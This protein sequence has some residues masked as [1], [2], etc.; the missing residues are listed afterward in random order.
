MVLKPILG[1]QLNQGHSLSQI[2]AAYWLMN[3]GGGDTIFD[4]SGKNLD[5]TL[6]N[7][8][9]FVACKFGTGLAF[10]GTNDYAFKAVTSFSYAGVSIACWAYIN[11]SSSGEDCMIHLGR[12]GSFEWFEL[13]SNDG[14]IQIGID[15]NGNRGGRGKTTYI[16]DVADT[17]KSGWHYFVAT[18][19]PGVRLRLYIDGIEY[20]SGVSLSGG[21]SEYQFTVGYYLA[22]VGIGGGGN[23][24]DGLI[25]HAVVFS[26]TLTASQ[27]AYLYRE[28]FAMFQPQPIDLWV[29]ATSVAIPPSTIIPVF[30]HHYMHS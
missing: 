7:E 19:E 29:A 9:S 27:V 21:V 22:F 25:D 26:T 4:L 2:L 14:R 15:D 10:D 30:M 20:G 1:T 17:Y 5:M 12:S 23:F 13:E 6:I 3:E 16:T 8:A 11:T 28:P 18:V 24:F